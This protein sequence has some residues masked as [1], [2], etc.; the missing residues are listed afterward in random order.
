MQARLGCF[1][2]RCS[3]FLLQHPF[4]LHGHSFW[5]LGTGLGI[6]DQRTMADQ[7]NTR[8]PPLRDTVT[9]PSGGWAVFRFKGDNPGMWIMHCHLFW[10][11][12]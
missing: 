6:Y 8:N 12:G 9:L 3:T 11:G 5:L 7:L 4:H 1:D 10:C 2:L